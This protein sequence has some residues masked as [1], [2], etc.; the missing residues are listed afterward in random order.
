MYFLSKN[1]FKI[2]KHLDYK[3]YGPY[4]ADNKLVVS[5]KQI[6]AGERNKQ[7]YGK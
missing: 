1:K 4:A 5:A 3:S 2:F 6:M 7:G